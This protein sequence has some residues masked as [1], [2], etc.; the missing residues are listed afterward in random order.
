MSDKIQV[1]LILCLVLV[2]PRKTGKHPDVTGNSLTGTQSIN[3]NVIPA[4]STLTRLWAC[5]GSS[6]SSLLADT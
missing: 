5:A 6:E 2:R 4:R 3:T 1:D